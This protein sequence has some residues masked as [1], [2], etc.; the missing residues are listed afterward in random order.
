MTRK[1]YYGFVSMYLICISVYFCF[2][3]KAGLVC[4]KVCDTTTFPGPGRTT[5]YVYQEYKK[6][7]IKL[8]TQNALIKL[9]DYICNCVFVIYM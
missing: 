4:S 9:Y 7:N 5:T 8:C 6:K 2:R 1:I 3:Y